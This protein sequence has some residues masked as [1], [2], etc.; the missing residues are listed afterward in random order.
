MVDTGESVVRPQ[1][2]DRMST[3]PRPGWT[4]W[5]WL[6]VGILLLQFAVFANV[7][8]IAAW[9]APVFLMRFV[10]SQRVAVA[11]PVIG[12]VG[13]LTVLVAMRDS[14]PAPDIYFF[15]LGGLTMVVSYGLTGCSRAGSAGYSA[16]WSSRPQTPHSS[17]WPASPT[18]TLSPR[19]AR[20][21]TPRPASC[22]SS[23]SSR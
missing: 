20:P 12:L 9:L 17:S 21:P 22:R 16:P 14:I 11:L 4:V 10:R 3:K 7:L 8:S 18:R 15:G 23:S 1:T 2:T 6:A 13:Y 19:S 5:P